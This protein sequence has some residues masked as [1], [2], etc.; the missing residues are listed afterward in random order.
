[1]TRWSTHL[2]RNQQTCDPHTYTEIIN[3]H[4]IHTPSQKLSRN[5]L[6]WENVLF[7]LAAT[8]LLQATSQYTF[9][10]SFMDRKHYFSCKLS[11]VANLILGFLS[12]QC[13]NIIKTFY[14]GNTPN[15]CNTWICQYFVGLDRLVWVRERNN[16]DFVR[17]KSLFKFMWFSGF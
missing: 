9:D 10:Y 7:L 2:H 1:M 8:L 17:H 12:C 15:I 6:P 16:S 5:M 11:I 4:V 3:R 13:V 14:K